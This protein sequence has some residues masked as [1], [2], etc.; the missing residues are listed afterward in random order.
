M[1]SAFRGSSAARRNE[2][3]DRSPTSATRKPRTNPRRKRPMLTKST[4]RVA[5]SCSVRRRPDLLEAVAAVDGSVQPRR[6]R[7]LSLLA[8]AAAGD[9][10]HLALRRSLGLG[11]RTIVGTPLRRVHEPLLLI[12]LLLACG[13]DEF[14]AAIATR[15][16]LV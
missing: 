10:V 2:P 3:T 13:P 8:T 11:A 5:G 14:V 15:Q 9:L 4:E 7:D 6:E 16:G 1:A 12:E